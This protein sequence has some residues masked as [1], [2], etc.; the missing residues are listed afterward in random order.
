MRPVQ[1]APII[2]AK[3]VFTPPK[4]K[5]IQVVKQEPLTSV[6]V[7][8][9]IERYDYKF[10]AKKAVINKVEPK[11]VLAQRNSEAKVAYAKIELREEPVAAAAVIEPVKE[12]KIEPEAF[13]PVVE[14][15]KPKIT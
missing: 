10:I 9:T 1:V 7:Q 6:I 13:T 11:S 3:P 8:P 5:V 2:V 15:E 14:I 12:K 4:A